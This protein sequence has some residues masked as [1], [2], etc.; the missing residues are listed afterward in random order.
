[1]KLIHGVGITVSFLA[2]F[3]SGSVSG[4]TFWGVNSLGG[5]GR[6]GVVF[7]TDKQAGNYQVRHVFSGGNPGSMPGHVTPLLFNGKLYGTTYAG[8]AANTGVLF[9]FDIASGQYEVLYE[10]NFDT[11]GAGPL[12]SL[13]LFNDKL[14]GTTNYG[15]AFSSGT[16]FEYDPITRE[17]SKR[18]EFSSF[19]MA[20]GVNPMAGLTAAGSS[21]Y[22]VLSGGTNN[23]GVLVEFY[24]ETGGTYPR[25]SFSGSDGS[26]PRYAMA[27][28]SNGK[29]Y[30]TTYL[31]GSHNGGVIFEYAPGDGTIT[32]LFDFD[33]VTGIYPVG[34]LVEA[35]GKFYGVTKQSGPNGMG[36][37]Y[38]FDPATGDT[39]V[40]FGFHA[41]TSHETSLTLAQSGMIY[42][43]TNSGGL[44]GV[45]SLFEFNPVLGQLT[46][47]HDFDHLTAS[48]TGGLTEGPNGELYGLCS[49]GG[50]TNNGVLFKYDP[51]TDVFTTL[52][53]M[54]AGTAR[55]AGQVL[56]VNGKV[57]G[58]ALSGGPMGYGVLYELDT[59]TNTFTEL[60]PFEGPN[61]NQPH[62]GLLAHGTRF[63]G[64]TRFGGSMNQG[65]IFQYDCNTR[66]FADVSF[67]GSLAYPHGQLFLLGDKLLGMTT[68]GTSAV[69]ELDPATRSLSTRLS[70][71]SDF[72]ACEPGGFV[73]SDG[74][75]FGMGKKGG[76]AN[77]G[78]I[79]KYDYAAN[80]MT[81]VRSFELSGGV[82][83]DGNLVKV[84]KRLYGVTSAGGLYNKGTIFEF[85]SMGSVYMPVYHFQSGNSGNTPNGGLM[86]ADDGQ[87]YGVTLAGGSND[88]GVIFKFNPATRVYSKQNDLT[89]ENGHRP[90][91]TTLI[92]SRKGVITSISNEP[93]DLI[94]YP[95]P[96][97]QTLNISGGEWTAGQ[98]RILDVFG[99]EMNS[100]ILPVENGVT[101]QVGHLPTGMYFIQCQGKNRTYTGRFIKK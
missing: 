36:A 60:V 97:T 26:Y 14:Y 59:L 87:L 95:I 45:G 66:E 75:L 1:M 42:G 101:I 56:L 78:F 57:Y 13:T 73:E 7:S 90:V 55:P 48:P 50:G 3:A 61:G 35:G 19:N 6:G 46:F 77:G 62:G 76:T 8:G 85:Y 99:R 63:Y 54:Q 22:G 51:A 64:L 9:S 79:Y 70:L 38:E 86:L 21:L 80:S 71:G 72:S 89:L 32:K 34:Q 25:V 39:E 33:D 67:T 91:S 5:P 65:T 100:Q 52:V 30:G 4:Q 43:M 15:G 96:A 23:H 93:D 18:S 2:F 37:L 44:Y 20:N 40:K 53:E 11:N 29:L 27:F 74:K 81:I 12:S 88:V 49:A 17:F 98:T 69:F 82:Y 84:G 31:G 16:I 58:T 10:F 41:S 24:P 68:G 47:L 83:P 92:D 28:G 94:V